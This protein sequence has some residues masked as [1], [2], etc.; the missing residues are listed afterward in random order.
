MAVSGRDAV[1]NILGEIPFSAE[2]FW[3]FRNPEKPLH[4]RFTLRN[5]QNAM[6]QL[7]TDAA[8]YL[9]TPADGKNIYIFSTLHYWIE[10]TA[11]LGL[12]MRCSGHRVTM[13]YLPYHDWQHPVNHFDLR[14]QNLYAKEV[15]NLLEPH[16]HSVSLLDYRTKEAE[17]PESLVK[18]VETVSYYDAQYTLQVET[19]DLNSDIYKLR[20]ERNLMA[21]RRILAQV[22]ALKPDVMIVPNGTIQE[23]GVAYRV[24]KHLGIPVTTYEFSDQRERIWLAQG[25][26][27]MRQETGPMWNAH[28]DTPFTEARQNRIKSLY[29]ARVQGA[30]W[31]NFARHWQASPMRGSAEVRAAL[32]LDDRPIILLATNVLGDSL[33]LGRQVFSKTMADWIER[34]VEYFMKRDDVQVV[35]RVHPGEVLT[36]GPSMVDVVNR[37]AP[38]LPQHIHLIGPRE[39]VNTYDIVAMADA[40]LVYTTTVGM[41]MA[42]NGIPVITAGQTHYRGRGFTFEPSSWEEYFDLLDKMIA[43]PAAYRL[44]EEKVQQAWHYAWCFFFAFSFMF[45]WRLVQLWDD[46]KERPLSY[47]LSPEGRE[48]YG[49]TFR[50]LAGD[51]ID[52][53]AQGNL[54]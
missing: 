49:A 34:S 3:L 20:Q 19:V 9:N 37:V 28:R 38:Q 2:L 22:Q 23:L 4:T 44:S 13:G 39:K 25:S 33:T 40:G 42:M 15:L 43:N 1:K 11:L 36:H 52:W 29:A 21:A 10:Q 45:P 16:V 6:P 31:E 50:Y 30:L 26:E 32:G 5:L 47:I 51:K 46:A 8:P 18:E 27:I 35:L 54:D 24:A 41:E 7:L 53:P 14:R 48:K 12:V 17:L